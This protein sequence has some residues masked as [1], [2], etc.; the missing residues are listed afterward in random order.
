MRPI[1]FRGRV[2]DDQ[3]IDASRIVYG[4]LVDHGESKYGYRYWIYPLEGDRNY[5]V[6]PDTVAQLVGYDAN[7]K[8]VYEGDTLIDELENE[9][10]AEIYDRPN[11]LATLTLKE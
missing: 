5:P 4:S 6:A 8:E 3:G 7:G 9:H 11:T 2:P 1:K 10:I